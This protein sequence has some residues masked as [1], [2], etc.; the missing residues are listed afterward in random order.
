[1]NTLNQV[2]IIQIQHLKVLNQRLKALIQPP[3]DR[4]SACEGS[5]STCEDIESR[6][7]EVDSSP[8]GDILNL[9]L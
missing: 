4:E 2:L 6:T 1:M 3:G 7:E 5:D 9:S 8:A